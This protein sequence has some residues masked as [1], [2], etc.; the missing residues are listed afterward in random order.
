MNSMYFTEEHHLFRKSLQDF[1]QK[2]VVPH[3]ENWEKTGTIDRFIWKKFG[4]MGFF[5]INYPEA[6]GG[7]NLDLFYTVILLEELQK[8]NSGGFAAAIWAHMYLAMTHLNA[9]G[10]ETI[11]QNYL[12]PSIAGDKIGC[13]CITEPF[14]GSD[15]AGMR[16]TAVKEGDY[17]ILNGSKTF[18][19]NGVYSDYLIVAAK[20]N[21]ELGNKGVSIFVVDRETEGIT[22]TK[23][24]KLGWRA[25]DTAE[26]A[27]DN[28]KIPAAN[29]MGEENK[30]FAYIMQHFSLE[31]LIMGINAHARAEFAL[32][33]AVQY[34][35]ERM[36]FGKFIDQ[37]Q[38]L[39]HSI[40]DLYTEMEICKEFNYSVAYRLNKGEYVVKHATMSKLKSTKMADDVIYQCLQFLGGY[41]YM[42]DYPLAR[43]LRDSRLGPIGGGTSEI[44][45]E[46]IAKIIIDKKEYK[47]ATK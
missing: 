18:I 37:F 32:E 47:P 25:S 21:P 1:L 16:S 33:Y 35:S 5:G 23:L 12:A 14:G 29:L 11:K 15:V 27:F 39:R 10:D 9:E 3:I 36:A 24:N 4:D 41:G 42:E 7:L 17:Y 26:I 30:G 6:Y 28:V 8:I 19:T 20:T 44:L 38:A 13:L 46:I 43:L 31:R 45:R 40:S 34:M 22:A 2:E